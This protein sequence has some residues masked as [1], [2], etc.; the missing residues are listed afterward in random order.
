MCLWYDGMVWQSY[1]FVSSLECFWWHGSTILLLI[2]RP[3]IFLVAWF[4]SP[5]TYS[6]AWN[7]FGGMVWQSCYFV[8]N[9][10]CFWWHGLTVLLLI[11]QPTMFLVAWFDSPVTYSP[12]W[13][14]FGGMVWQSCYSVSN[15]GCFW[16]HGLTVLLLILQPGMFLVAWFDSPVTYSPACN[17]FGGM[18]WQ[19][20]YLVSNL[21]C[22]WWH[23]LTVLLLCL[24]SGLFLT[25]I[26]H[27]PAV[28]EHKY[29]SLLCVTHIIVRFHPV[30]FIRLH[31]CT[32]APQF[33]SF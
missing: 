22:F 13:N 23:G 26:L 11:L 6:P 3:G 19:S 25:V 20:C 1:Y 4:H 21:G 16:W 17:I 24:Q 29:S 14:I 5:V 12:A 28:A 32:Y 15:L 8:S 18:V 31:V 10:G 30:V 9:L 2:L 33:I 27:R 7:I